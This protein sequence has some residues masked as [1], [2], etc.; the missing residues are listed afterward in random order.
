M[1]ELRINAHNVT[2]L[3]LWKANID[4]QYVHSRSI[5]WCGICNFLHWEISARYVKV[6][7]RCCIASESRR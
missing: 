2:L 5:C 4:L 7:E 3:Y 6:I 1:N